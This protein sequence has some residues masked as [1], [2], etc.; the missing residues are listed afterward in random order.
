MTS[1]NIIVATLSQAEQGFRQ[2]T[3][4]TAKQHAI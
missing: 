1:E 2:E 4:K 3:T